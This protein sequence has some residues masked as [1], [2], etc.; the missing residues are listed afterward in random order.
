LVVKSKVTKKGRDLGGVFILPGEA[1]LNCN[2]LDEGVMSASLH[3]KL[4]LIKTTNHTL[5]HN[6]FNYVTV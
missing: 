6:M 4:L 3:V 5:Y 2:A 1:K